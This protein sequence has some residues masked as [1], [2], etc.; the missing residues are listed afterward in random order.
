L[1]NSTDR[2]IGGH[3]DGSV[4]DVIVVCRNI[5]HKTKYREKTFKSHACLISIFFYLKGAIFL[6][7][8]LNPIL[9]AI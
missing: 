7:L 2:N 9:R 3:E 8:E 1:I 6:K 4:F 5:F